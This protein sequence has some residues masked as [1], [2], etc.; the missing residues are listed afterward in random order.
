VI[1]SMQKVR[2]LGPRSRIRSVIRTLQD[3]GVVHL[4]PL[5]PQPPLAAVAP[6]ARQLRHVARVQRALGDVEEALSRLDSSRPALAP[7][8]EIP[9]ESLAREVRLARRARRAAVA[10][11]G[12]RRAVADERERLLPLIDVMQAFCDMGVVGR[13]ATRTFLLVFSRA[14]EE[15]IERFRG[16]L[17]RTIGE[18]FELHEA[19]I[20][21]GELA[22]ALVVPEA[23][24]ARIEALLP[25]AGVRE[26][27]LPEGCES[28]HPADALDALRQRLASIDEQLADF[29][30]RR[31]RLA[32]WLRPGLHR[33]R[34]ALNDWLIA[35]EA[36]ANAA[37]SEYLFA[38]EGWLPDTGRD[39]LGRALAEREGEVIVIEDVARET[40]SAR[41]VPVAIANPRVFRPFEVITRWLPLPRYGTMDPTPLVAVFFP[42]FFGLILGDLGYGAVLAIVALLFWIRSRE[43]SLL[44]SVA[45]VAAVCAAFSMIFGFV[46]GELFG[47][48]G[49]RLL[50]MRAV[51]FSREDA[52]IPFL[53]L[54]LSL[55]F[56][57]VLL[58][59]VL[60]AISGFRQDPRESLGRGLSA[61]MLL[62]TA[63]TL[64][65]A[66]NVL[67][68]AF[69]T[70]SVVALI[71]S[72]SCR[73]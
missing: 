42:M 73:A 33:A 50:G 47:D 32:D 16:L 7:V 12:E 38:I 1:V 65:A 3:V 26:L 55:G 62:L 59:L 63:S 18:T 20:G 68:E 34:M 2:I 66:L 23:H 17:A 60:G 51:A 13:A 15:G 53:V 31:E 49:R 5:V 29:A 10:L 67:P 54:A 52:F 71:L 39:G 64:L 48:L 41:D 9:V 27:E 21:A 70:P 19:P 22:T 6:T 24:A 4:C 44:R 43:G 25:E 57:H 36:M 30:L 69:F 45:E 35:N 58:G 8:A 72:S 14:G 56:V 61:V 37:A 40:W 46:F 11:D 28:T